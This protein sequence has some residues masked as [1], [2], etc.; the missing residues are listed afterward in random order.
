MVNRSDSQAL[1]RKHLDRQLS[2]LPKQAMTRPPRGWLRAIRDSLGL[3]TRQLA[4]RMGKNHSTI[5]ALE[6]G[7]VA[8]TTTLNSLKDV[9]EALNC[10]LVYAIVPKQPLESMVRNQARKK[11]ERLLGRVSHTMRLENQAVARSEQAEQ[12]DRLAS[13]M[14]T[15]NSSAIWDDA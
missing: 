1:A 15:R 12:I 13:D 6:Q 11:A 10:T 3:T 7:E 14:L 4:G 5:V 2:G 8:G 9:A